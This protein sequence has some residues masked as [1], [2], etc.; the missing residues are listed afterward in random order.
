MVGERM[1]KDQENRFRVEIGSY[2]RL[3]ALILIVAVAAI[4]NPNFLS[5]YNVNALLEDIGVL[6]IVSIGLFNGICFTRLRIPSFIVTLGSMNIFM[7]IAMLNSGS[8]SVSISKPYYGLIK[9]VKL[10]LG[11][12]PIAFII[13]MVLL[14]LFV[15]V[16]IGRAHV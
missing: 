13:A 9:W 1:R 6:L 16:Q 5:A 11:I 4:A 7:S 2:V 3:M 15:Y 14:A 10:D 8:K 12:F